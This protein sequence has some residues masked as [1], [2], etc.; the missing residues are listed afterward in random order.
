MPLGVLLTEASRQGLPARVRVA[1][2]AAGPSD[3]LSPGKPGF[4]RA[5]TARPASRTTSRLR[6]D[7]PGRRVHRALTDRL[8]LVQV[9]RED[10]PEPEKAE[11]AASDVRF[12]GYFSRSG[13]AAIRQTTPRRI[14]AARDRP[15]QQPVR[16][17]PFSDLAG[18]QSRSATMRLKPLGDP[19]HHLLLNAIVAVG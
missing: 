16:A 13:R 5:S 10:Q 4:D 1:D 19:A 14:A 17:Q 15:K 3:R 18:G 12:S 8:A 7:G 9:D 6:R 2:L 11:P